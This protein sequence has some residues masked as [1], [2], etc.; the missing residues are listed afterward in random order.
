M[1]VMM[2]TVKNFMIVQSL[3]SRGMMRERRRESSFSGRFQRKGAVR[4]T[5]MASSGSSSWRPKAL[6]RVL[7]SSRGCHVCGVCWGSKGDS[8]QENDDHTGHL[9][10][11]PLCCICSQRKGQRWCGR[12]K[13]F[14]K[15]CRLRM[16]ARPVRIHA[17]YQ[18]AEQEEEQVARELVHE[19]WQKASRDVLRFKDHEARK[20]LNRLM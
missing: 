16:E 7:T 8:C 19:L 20:L 3:L 14:C 13:P 15:G 6:K 9:R 4:V 18:T 1:T 17:T 10:W 11:M 2:M 5:E 12:K